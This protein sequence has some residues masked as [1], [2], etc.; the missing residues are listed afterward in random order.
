MPKKSPKPELSIEQQLEKAKKKVKTLEKLLSEKVNQNISLR[1]DL[2]HEKN[3][4]KNSQ[5]NS[6]RNPVKQCFGCRLDCR[7]LNENM[8]Y[9]RKEC[10]FLKAAMEG[11]F[12]TKGPTKE[13]VFQQTTNGQHIVD[14]EA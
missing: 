9:R 5:I 14:S 11:I 1:I 12:M 6:L 4:K 13:S 3:A 8:E 2:F 10:T 7:H